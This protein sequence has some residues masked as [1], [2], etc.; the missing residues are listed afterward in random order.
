MGEPSPVELILQHPA[1]VFY[2]EI[3]AMALFSH[4]AVDLLSD[5]P[6]GHVEVLQYPSP[7]LSEHLTSTEIDDDILATPA[8]TQIV[9]KEQVQWCRVRIVLPTNPPP[10]ID[11]IKA[12]WRQ[13]AYHRE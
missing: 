7:V 9:S 3:S 11:R 5:D 2:S 12:T 13:I 1:T 4:R 8:Q 10:T 6:F